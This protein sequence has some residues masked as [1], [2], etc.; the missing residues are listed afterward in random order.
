MAVVASGGRE[1]VT[2]YRVI[3]SYGTR[4]KPAVAAL[5][6]C[7]LETGRTHQIRVH[8]ATIGHPLVG[9]RTYGAGFATKATLLP[10]PARG[11]AEAFPRQA[12]HAWLLA[13]EHPATGEA[14]RFERAP[15]ADMRR[16][17][18]TLAPL[19]LL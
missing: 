15:P 12:L 16:L 3:E 1:A 4:G 13:F 5:V 10:E 19:K 18:E 8:M 6:D 11:L 7:R 9:D 14:M 17:R 2:H